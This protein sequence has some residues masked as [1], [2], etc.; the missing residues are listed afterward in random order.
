[1]P[2][3][4][5]I[6]ERELILPA[7]FLIN[8]RKGITTSDLIAELT[9]LMHPS[10]EDAEILDGRKDSKFSQK[11]RNLVS[12]NTLERLGYATYQS[13]CRYKNYTNFLNGQKIDTF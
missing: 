10:G 12:H 1:M 3:A 5:R 8:L 9:D 13:I 7:L 2:G 6:T 11:V 4:E